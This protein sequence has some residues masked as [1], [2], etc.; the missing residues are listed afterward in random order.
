[1]NL[2]ISEG[3]RFMF[4]AGGVSGTFALEGDADAEPIMLRNVED[5]SDRK[6]ARLDLAIL[7]GNGRVLRTFKKGQPIRMLTAPEIQAYHEPPKSARLSETALKN[8]ET[9]QK[10]LKRASRLLFYAK[11]W[12]DGP[13]GRGDVE[14]ERFIK[15]TQPDAEQAG[16]MGKPSVSSIRKA[17]AKGFGAPRTLGMYL[18]KTGGAREQSNWPDWVYDL[19][20][21]MVRWYYENALRKYKDAHQWF[22]VRF[23][24]LRTEWEQTEEAPSF[25]A[26]K[27]LEELAPPCE[28]TLTNWIKAAKTHATLTQKYGAREASRRLRGRSKSLEP[29]G[30]LE[31]IVLDQTLAPIWAV[32]KVDVDGSIAIVLKRPWIVWALDLYSR[33]VVGFIMTFDPPNIAT[34]MACLRHIIG[35]KVEWIDRFGAMKG[36]T[37]GFGAF[38]NVILDNA[39][40]HFQKTMQLVGDVAGY[41]VELAP[42]YTPEFKSWVERFNATMNVALRSLPG[43]IPE[44]EDK[45]AAEHDAR[46]SAAL[47]IESIRG[48]LPHHIMRYHLDV[49]DGINMAPARKWGEGLREFDRPIVD[50]ARAF[51]LLLGRYDSGVLGA[52]GITFRGLQFHDQGITTMLLNHFSRLHSKR[53]GG[54]SGQ[55]SRFSVHFIYDEMNTSTMTV[56]DEFSHEMVELPNANELHREKPVSFAFSDGEREYQRRQN[57][58]FHTREEKAQ[59]RL[60]YEKELEAELAKASHGQ[61]KNII[62]VLKGREQL[63]LGPSGM[64][65]DLKVPATIDGME[66]PQGIPMA[67]SF[68]DRVDPVVANKGRKPPGKRNPQPGPIVDEATDFCGPD[69]VVIEGE[70]SVVSAETGDDESRLDELARRFGY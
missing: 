69:P 29:V 65:L 20:H 12:D 35:P 6:I 40:A 70:F 57:K 8:W 23:Y 26:E 14:L 11:A 36:A 38:Y 60:E 44:A 45:A 25:L 21:K 17:I 19:G 52:S 42:I 68:A 46:A 58:Q 66:K 5:G 24:P 49:H 4:L 33:M 2:G 53:D 31:T 28:E 63:S 54:K 56:I 34:L 61:G 15:L 1:M 43:G 9:R 62:R 51:K 47:S 48:L 39:K 59:A 22:D 16:H 67:M 18:R 27:E 13:S 10:D 37:D 55:S 50:D 64:V 32:E 3:D 7:L 30:P 41:K